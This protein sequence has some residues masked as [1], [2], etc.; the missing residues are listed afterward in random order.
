VGAEYRIVANCPVLLATR[1]V[2]TG[3]NRAWMLAILVGLPLAAPSADAAF[4]GGNGRIAY[5]QGDIGAVSPHGLSLVRRD[6][7]PLGPT[8]QEGGDDPCP[9]NPSWARNGGRLAFDLGGDL[10]LINADGGGY[11]RFDV[12][13]VKA[14]RPAWAPD[15]TRIVFEG[16][17]V[18]AR[19]RELYLVDVSG[20]NPRRLTSGGG[21]HPAWSA[22]D[23]IAF[24]RNGDLHVMR[25]DGGGL[26]RLTSRG[27]EQP[28]W[29]PSA[30]QIVFSRGRGLWRMAATGGRATRVVR[31]G[32][33][34][35][36]APNGKRILY[37][38]PVG[39]YSRIVS[40]TPRGKRL[41]EVTAGE[42]G[43]GYFVYAP[44][45]EAR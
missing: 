21:R 17:P 16:L 18:G 7:A 42:E 19:E 15:G 10:A 5:V 35:A 38:Q 31:R 8:C 12:P 44:D 23:R 37:E 30:R 39:D 22:N 25:P 29:S 33:E 26:R 24:V 27:G 43:R 45:Q 36:W 2:K 6:F 9:D 34:P 14:A 20:A 4:P 41:K 13:G 11:A 1:L 40:V 32:S 28:N 3:H